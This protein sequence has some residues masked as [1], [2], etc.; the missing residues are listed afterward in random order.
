[1]SL[2]GRPT[3]IERQ[4]RYGENYKTIIVNLILM[5]KLKSLSRIGKV[6]E[7]CIDTSLKNNL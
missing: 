4:I 6:M 1:M 3:D 2:I 7:G 5:I